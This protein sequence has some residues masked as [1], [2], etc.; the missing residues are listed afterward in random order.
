MAI[1]SRLHAAPTKVELASLA[2]HVRTAFVFLDSYTALRTSTHIVGQG[3]ASECAFLLIATGP[4]FVPRLLA[5][6]AGVL[7]TVLALDLDL[8]F[9]LSSDIFLALE[10]RAPDL[11]II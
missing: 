10:I 2:D 8:S 5:L 1:S 9:L 3:E 4:T 11:V 6:P 7:L